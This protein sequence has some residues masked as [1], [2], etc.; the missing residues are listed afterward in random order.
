M[1][2]DSRWDEEI[3][4]NISDLE[5]K[6]FYSKDRGLILEFHTEHSRESHKGFKGVFTFLEKSK[7][8]GFKINIVKIMKFY[9]HKKCGSK[10]KILYVVDIQ[11]KHL[12]K[13]VFWISTTNKILTDGF[14]WVPIACIIYS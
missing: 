2:E 8:F 13:T 14:F 3:C 4:G 5:E 1:N 12:N 10:D 6:K 9:T 7:Y 11:K